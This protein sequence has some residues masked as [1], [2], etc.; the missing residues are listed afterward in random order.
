MFAKYREFNRIE[1]LSDIRR[2]PRAKGKYIKLGVKAI[3]KKTGNEY[4]RE[5]DFFICPPEVEAVYG[6]KPKELDIFFPVNDPKVF[7]PQYFEW[8]GSSAGVKCRGDGTT[9]DR[10]T[11][12]G[13]VQRECP[14]E[15]L[16]KGNCKR[17][18]TLHVILPRVSIWGVYQIST[19]SYNSIIDI[20]SGIDSAMALYRGKIAWKP[21]KL[22]REPIETHPN[23][24]KQ[25]HYTLHIKPC[26]LDYFIKNNEEIYTALNVPDEPK[27]IEKPEEP[28]KDVE[29]RLDVVTD[30]AKKAGYKGWKSLTQA[31]PTIFGDKP[32]VKKAK[33]SVEEEDFTY[34]SLINALSD[35]IKEKGGDIN[36]R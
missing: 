29:N 18:G 19:S 1:G 4:T 24:A 15:E 3:S 12:K 35:K 36:E 34:N 21:F 6:S 31:F 33:K 9:A 26:R 5:T 20:N 13:V 25:I 23:G 32:D 16:E 10:N 8:R 11:D 7:F 17:K 28:K 27:M 14:C 2:F 22:Y 30:L